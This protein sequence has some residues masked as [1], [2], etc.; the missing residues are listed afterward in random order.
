MMMLMIAD[1]VDD[2]RCM[3]FFVHIIF[4]SIFGPCIY[5]CVYGWMDGWMYIYIENDHMIYVC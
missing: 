5:V 2:R 4:Y 1:D 3:L